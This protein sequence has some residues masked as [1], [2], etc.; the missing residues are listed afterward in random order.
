MEYSAVVP[1]ILVLL[2]LIYIVIQYNSFVKKRNRIKQV[3]HTMD[4]ML[5]KRHDTIPN[6]VETVKGY[7]SHEQEIFNKITEAREKAR[8]PGHEDEKIKAESEISDC[9]SRLVALIEDT[10]ELKARK[11]ALHL[12]RSIFEIEKQINA[13]RRALNSVVK[14]YNTSIQTFPNFILANIFGFKEKPY[15]KALSEAYSTPKLN[16]KKEEMIRHDGN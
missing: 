11:N 12:Q 4:A 13:S 3:M 5:Q 10:P 2:L 1:V 7:M 9:M 6:L 16:M 15:F 14:D 8:L